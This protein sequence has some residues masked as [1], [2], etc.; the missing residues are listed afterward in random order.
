MT[1]GPH[2][3][4]ARD[5]ASLD[6]AGENRGQWHRVRVRVRVSSRP[7]RG[8]SRGLT[9]IELT[10]ALG[11]IVILLSAAVWG[12]GAFTGVR[13]KES[14][15]NLAGTIRAL[16]DSAALS[17][18]TC[19]LVF[20]LPQERD[21]EGQVHW[22]AECAKGAVTAQAERDE[23]LRDANSSVRRKKKKVADDD[24]RFR[25]LGSTS[26]PTLEELQAR[27]K[28]RVEEVAKF[29]SFSSEDVVE[30]SLEQQ[31]QV[32]V[33]TQKQRHAV[34]SGTAYLYFFPQGYT[35]RARV[36][37]TQGSNTW[38]LTISPLTGK[39]VIHDERLEVPR[40]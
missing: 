9:L 25:R 3:R 28:S 7:R 1:K 2:T 20:E 8:S 38:T 12:I 40:S 33:W 22:R 39:T 27:E 23:E 6:S 15:T 34:T 17:G 16:Y 10:V 31:V 18:R 19:R 13:A 32:E 29:S 35:E 24:T 21:E 36:W 5:P 4:L 11:V 26:A 14:A 37:V 30:Q